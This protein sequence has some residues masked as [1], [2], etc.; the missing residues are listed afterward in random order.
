MKNKFRDNKQGQVTVFIILAILI[1][2]VIGLFFVFKGDIIKQEVPAELQGVYDYY[3]SCIELE[4][5]D[6]GAILGQ[7]GGYIE[8]PEFEPGS[9]YMPFSNQLDFLGIGVPYWYY[10]SG[11]GIV[12]EQ[13][14]SKAKMQVQLNE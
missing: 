8:P 13:I 3:L 12:N 7:Q 2:A 9:E 10:V 1:V 11:N 6:G 5:I 14:P 4:A